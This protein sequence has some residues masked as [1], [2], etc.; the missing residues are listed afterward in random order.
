MK[1]RRE[2]RLL[3]EVPRPI[4]LRAKEE[5]ELASIDYP[6]GQQET[7]ETDIQE[8][9]GRKCVKEEAMISCI[10]CQ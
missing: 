4:E 6:A 3:P 8:A 7:P 10:A 9:N 5:G 2:P 1:K